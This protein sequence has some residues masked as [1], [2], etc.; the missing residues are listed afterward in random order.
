M[1]SQLDMRQSDHFPFSLHENL[2]AADQKARLF[3]TE[4]QPWINHIEVHFEKLL[5]DTESELRRI[6]H[7]LEQP[8]SHNLK[9]IVKPH[10]SRHSSL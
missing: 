8:F 9:K 6:C 4:N 10:L 2:E 3:C 1:A 5:K 7:F